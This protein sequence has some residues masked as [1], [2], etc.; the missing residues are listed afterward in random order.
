MPVGGRCK[1]RQ[2]LHIYNWMTA[3][4][5]LKC[6]VNNCEYRA[7]WPSFQFTAKECKLSIKVPPDI[8]YSETSPDLSLQEGENATLGCKATGHPEPRVT[9]RRED[10][11]L[12][13]MRRPKGELS[14]SDISNNLQGN[15]VKYPQ[16]KNLLDVTDPYAG[17]FRLQTI[18]SSSTVD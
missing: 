8:V 9:W 10:G 13:I 11:D 6:V 2:I 15:S 5:T 1:Y 4:P 3:I 16:D 14:T 7:F 18:C 12:I 17:H